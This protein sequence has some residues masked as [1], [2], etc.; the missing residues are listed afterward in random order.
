LVTIGIVGGGLLG[1]L[2]LAFVLLCVCAAPI[3]VAAGK[4]DCDNPPAPNT[5]A[6]ARWLRECAKRSRRD[7]V[8][9]V[10]S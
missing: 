3:A 5:D 6:H 7:G 8:P 4:I 9:L 10:T 2:A 1:S